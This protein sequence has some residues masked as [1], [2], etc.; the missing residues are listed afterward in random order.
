[1]PVNKNALGRYRIID[2]LLSDPNNDFTTAD[3]MSRVNRKCSGKVTLRMIQ[4]DIKSLEE[5][6]GKKMVRNA[7]G[8]GTVKYEDQSDPLF[9]QELTPDEEEVL[10]I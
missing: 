4:K 7:G 5:D 3:I 9:Y 10:Q 1:M 8:R 2:K 6:F